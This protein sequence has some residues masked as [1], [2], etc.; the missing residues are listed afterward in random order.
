MRELA[1]PPNAKPTLSKSRFSAGLQCLKRL[2]LEC[3]SRELADPVDSAQQAVFDSGTE[4]GELARER[5]PG[6]LLI[7]EPYNEHSHAEE[8]TLKAIADPVVPAIYE[9]AFTFEGIRVRVDV[10]RRN[11]DGAFDL[12]EVKSSTKVKP[13][14][15][16]DAAIQ[17]HVLEGAGVSIR[18][19]FLLHID[20]SYVYD[21][22]SYDLDKLFHLEDITEKTRENLSSIPRSLSD[23]WET[24]EDDEAP[25]VEIGSHCSKPYTCAFYS[26]CRRGAPE[27]HIEQLPRAS[28]KLL[29]K[30]RADGIHD[31]REI[32][33]EFES[34]SDNQQR[35][36]DS[37]VTGQP[38][39]GPELSNALDQATFP[40]S[41]LDFE[42][43]NPVLP[44]YPGTRPYQIIP[45]QWSLHRLDAAGNLSHTEFLQE[46]HEDPREMVATSLLDAIGPD[47]SI[48]VYSSYERTTIRRLA[49]EFPQFEEPLLA[50]CDRIFDLYTVVTKYYYHPEFHGSYSLKSVM[51]T[52]VPGLTYNELEIQGGSNASVAFAQMIAPDTP[53]HERRKIRSALLDYCRLDTQ[54]MVEVLKAL[55]SVR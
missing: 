33:T 25:E 42:T 8:S 50:L 6:G 40:L 19:V 23:M 18:N 38:H 28:A 29:K 48:V 9:P 51:P 34:L 39:V 35:V 5:F 13:E 41:F 26:Y 53:E 2:Y 14:H 31:I 45:F 15:I 44:A 37:V 4:V 1:M 12:V 49:E 46:G 7:K 16:P 30:L 3:Y 17:L 36:R 27:H 10:L 11:G 22:G 55:R 32:P 54:A 43:F 21:G 20:N 52:L 47:G 24:L